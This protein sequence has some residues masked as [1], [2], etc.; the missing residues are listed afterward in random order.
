VLKKLS[1]V[2]GIIALTIVGL[3]GIGAIYV[4]EIGL[5]VPVDL[6]GDGNVNVDSWDKGY[7]QA[8]GTWVI[9]GERHAWPLNVSDLNCFRDDQLCYV[10][11][12]RGQ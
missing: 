12:A 11:S 7:V 3:I 1:K 4:G 2:L 5:R 6:R 9:D 10:A 8:K